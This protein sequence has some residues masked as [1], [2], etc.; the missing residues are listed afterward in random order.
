MKGKQKRPNP[1]QEAFQA[2]FGLVKQNPV[3][4][5]LMER[6]DVHFDDKIGRASCRER[7]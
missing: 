5:S 3:L 2:G 7:V 4:G 6:A 1:A